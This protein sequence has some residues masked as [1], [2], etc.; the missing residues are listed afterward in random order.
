MGWSKVT[1]E[2][3]L[4][5]GI[6]EMHCREYSPIIYV[7]Q[8]KNF[9]TEEREKKKSWGFGNWYLSSK[10]CKEIYGPQGTLAKS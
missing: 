7:G 10:I 3:G 6:A 5:E 9:N 4:I 1:D 2:H 8:I